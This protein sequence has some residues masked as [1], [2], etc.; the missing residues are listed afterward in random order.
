M[1]PPQYQPQYQGAPPYYG[2]PGFDQQGYGY[3]AQAY[4]RQS[5]AT[6]ALVLSIM[7]F[8]CCGVPSIIGLFM[9]QSELA[10][11]RRGDVDPTNHGTARAAFIIGMIVSVLTLGVF[12]LWIVAL[13][14]SAATSI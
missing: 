3:P 2:A 6:V 1:Q 14:A 11:I 5:Q 4:P 8:M 7:G 12:V 10:A 9:A 13:F